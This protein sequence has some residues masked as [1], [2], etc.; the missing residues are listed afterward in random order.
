MKYNEELISQVKDGELAIEN[1]G[2]IAELSNLLKFIFP[3]DDCKVEGTCKFYFS[4]PGAEDWRV[5]NKD[6]LPSRPVQDFLIQEPK[7]KIGD[8]VEWKGDDL[9]K[10]KILKKSIYPKCW[11]LDVKV[12]LSSYNACHEDS[13]RL[14]SPEEIPAQEPEFAWGEEVEVRD[15]EN[16]KWI[17]SFFV[18]MNPL[19]DSKYRYIIVRH[20]GYSDSYQFCRKTQRKTTLTR[21]QIADKFG[22][23]IDNLIIE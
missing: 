8:W 20:S 5:T 11:A 4:R 10:G 1:T 6:K 17:L 3:H 2:T 12:G 13:L 19:S 22:I 7:F 21:Q 23:E 18:G 16:Y 15:N 14:L 9:T